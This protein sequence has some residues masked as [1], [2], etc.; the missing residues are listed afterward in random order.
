M[1][2]ILADIDVRGQEQMQSSFYGHQLAQCR[3][4]RKAWELL[5]VYW[6]WDNG[7]GKCPLEARTRDDLG[8][9]I[10]ETSNNMTD[11]PDSGAQRE[12][13]V[14]PSVKLAMIFREGMTNA[15]GFG[16]SV[17][18]IKSGYHGLKANME[19]L[20]PLWEDFTTLVTV[21]WRIFYENEFKLPMTSRA[22][23]LRFQELKH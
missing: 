4:E 19:S 8:G 3:E 10:L 23:F 6:A 17:C 2:V 16:F 7:F 12:S 15:C 22:V 13:S 14:V 18:M 1:G 11:K 9:R 5:T 21:D 20:L